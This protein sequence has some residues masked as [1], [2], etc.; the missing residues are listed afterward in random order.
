MVFFAANCRFAAEPEGRHDLRN[1]PHDDIF[2]LY[3]VGMSTKPSRI[4]CFAIV[5]RLRE[6]RFIPLDLIPMAF[7]HD[8]I[9]DAASKLPGIYHCD[10][11]GAHRNPNPMT[12]LR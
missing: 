8:G 9:P 7:N 1:T 2:I 4:I 3:V 12:T 6:N 11:L 10:L 5:R